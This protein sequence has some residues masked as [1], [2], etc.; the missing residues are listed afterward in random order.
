MTDLHRT[1]EAV[2]RIEWA[3]LVAGL[4]RRV[5]DV[6]LAEELAQDALLA[7]FEQW[8]ESGV[9]Q[10][11]GAWLMAAGKNQA[12]DR[13]RRGEMV[14]RKH[15]EVARELEERQNAMPDLEALDDEVGDDLLRLML[16]A[17][18]PVLPPDGRVALTLRLLGGL[19]TGEIARAFLVPEPTVAQRIV[20]AKKKLAEAN[21]P[22][23]APRG[24]ELARRLGSVLEVIYLVF[25]EGYA[26]TSGEDWLRPALCEEALRLG[27]ILAGL[28]P[29]EPEVHGLVALMEIQASRSRARHRA[30]RRAD[31]AA[32]AGSRPLGPAA[33]PP[34]PRRA[35]PRRKAGRRA[36]TVPPSRRRSPPAT[37]APGPP[38]KPTGR[39]SPRFTASWRGRCPRRSSSSTARSRWRMAEGPQAGLDLIDAVREEPIL[40]DYHL[41]PS[42]R[43][44]FLAKLGRR[45]EALDELE[46]AVALATNQ[47]EKALLAE[48]APLAQAG[49]E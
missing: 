1:I 34:R 37:P 42:V 17:C 3:T 28:T 15:Q 11:P 2:F 18:H 29:D 9:P 46:R 30:G 14:E 16:I 27:R 21:V 41:L 32:R 43:A 22:F 39:G 40:G 12:I 7:A 49:G 19:E 8:P 24:A 4:T 31:P 48:R 44:D 26:A 47:R 36:G 25:N 23:E 13:L 20:R 45:E 35:R 33:D 6:G 10:K 38:P 5:R